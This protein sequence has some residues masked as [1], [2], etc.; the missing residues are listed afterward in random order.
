MRTKGGLAAALL[1]VDGWVIPDQVGDRR[2]AMTI[3][4]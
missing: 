4:G 1:A 3:I 2:P